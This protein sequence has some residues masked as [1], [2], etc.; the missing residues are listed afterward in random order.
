MSTQPPLTIEEFYKNMAQKRLTGGKCKKCG[1]VHVPP[2]PLCDQCLSK[3]FEWVELPKTGKLLTYTVIHVAPVQFQ[4]MAPYAVGIVQLE[5]GVKIPGIIK[6]AA[7]EQ[8]KIG[9]RL[10]MEFEEAPQTQQ[11]P[12]WPRYYF[13]PAA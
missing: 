13:K 7:P 3:D 6:G 1:K 9:M 12:A 2:R 10:A 5:N 11:W 8:L 4:S